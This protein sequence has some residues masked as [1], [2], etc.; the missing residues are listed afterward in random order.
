VGGFVDLFLRVEGTELQQIWAGDR[1]IIGAPKNVF[2]FPYIASFQNQSASKPLGKR[3]I[4]NFYPPSK[5]MA[6]VD[7]MFE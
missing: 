7:E 6:G 3:Q 2:N 5:I 4:S 1:Y